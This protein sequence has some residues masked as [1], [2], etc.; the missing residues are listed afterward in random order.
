MKYTVY[1]YTEEIEYLPRLLSDGKDTTADAAAPRAWRRRPDFPKD[2]KDFEEAL[3]ESDVL[4]LA[5]TPSTDLLCQDLKAR[6]LQALSRGIAVRSAVTFIGRDLEDLRVA[7][8]ENDTV[9]ELLSA[10]EQEDVRQ[11]E[12][13]P[14]DTD[15]GEGSDEEDA[16]S[17]DDFD[18]GF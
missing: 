11:P 10:P 17:S 13:L 3:Q 5:D 16:G 15:G 1:P 14:T 12:K 4:L 7:A 8:A 9:L 2:I 6:A 18:W